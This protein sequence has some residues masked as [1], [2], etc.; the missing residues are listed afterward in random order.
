VALRGGDGTH[1][2]REGS[3]CWWASTSNGQWWVA[4]L[5]CGHS[6]WLVDGIDGCLLFMGGAGCS[7]WLVMVT[8]NPGVISH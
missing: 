4:V 1:K 7:L 5:V 3:H 6:L 8:G 2:Q